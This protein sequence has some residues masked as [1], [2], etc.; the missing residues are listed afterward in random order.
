[1]FN[2]LRSIVSLSRMRAQEGH[3]PLWQQSA[4]IVALWLL[5][6]A[7]PS[8]YHMAGFWRREL[9]WSDKTCHLNRREY[10]QVLKKLN[11]E[12][13]RKLS[14]N[15]IAEK[16]IL[17]LFNLPTPAFVG[18]LSMQCGMDSHGAPL[19]SAHD[20]ETLIRTKAPQRLVFKEL[21]GFGGKGVQI[22][23]I[24]PTD[25][26]ACRPLGGTTFDSVR[27]YCE[28]TLYLSKGGDW[29]VEEYLAQHPLVA[30]FNPTSVNTIRIWVLRTTPAHTEVLVA[31]L[32]IGRI[33]AWVDNVASGGIIAP[34]DVRT[35]IL[36][37]GQ[38]AQAERRFYPTHPDHGTA[39]EGLKLPY[40]EQVPQVA[41][42][43]LKAFPGLRFA[44]LDIAIGDRGPV[45]VELNVVPDREG[46]GRLD[47]AVFRRLSST[48]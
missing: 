15:K 4:E 42:D 35:G 7:G 34:I 23:E 22:V 21:E 1:M 5:R 16:A 43:A 26:T 19:K 13:Y 24:S 47:G 45:I 6:G 39:I 20:L 37:A 46:A 30:S 36:G 28:S 38:A 25:P 10:R 2:K 40:W 33:G 17:S 8:Y 48:A 12:N 3:L 14:Q 9:K 29:L 32:R 11:P 27:A 31:Y 44:G 41:Q 18:R